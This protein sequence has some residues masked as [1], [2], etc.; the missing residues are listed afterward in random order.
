MFDIWTVNKNAQPIEQVGS[1]DDP[2]VALVVAAQILKKCGSPALDARNL[3]GD[4]VWPDEPSLI[5]FDPTMTIP[6]GVVIVGSMLTDS[7]G[8]MS[9]TSVGAVPLTR[10]ISE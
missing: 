6:M 3:D 2:Q 4:G 5:V 8:S 1:E 9:R 10:A 7:D